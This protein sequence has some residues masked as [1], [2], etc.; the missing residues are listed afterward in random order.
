MAGNVRE[1]CLNPSGGDRYILG[2]S[3]S[4]PSYKFLTADVCSSLDRSSINGFRCAKY[5]RI[6]P[7]QLTGPVRLLA[8]DRRGDKPAG[9]ASYQAYRSFH[10]YTRGDLKPAIES[11]EDKQYW[12]QE[13]VSFQAAYGDERVMAYLYLPKNAIPP[14]QTIVFFPG[15]NALN[16]KSSSN[17]DLKY[18]DFI[19]R[20]DG[21]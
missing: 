11:S 21:H 13:K 14:F 19:I 8:A 4:E 16:T 18:F 17:L 1:W 10:K 2:G 5:N 9:D 6:L 15:S 3:W 12:H 7:Q 20:A